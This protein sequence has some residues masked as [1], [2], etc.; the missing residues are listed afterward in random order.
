MSEKHNLNI[1]TYSLE[2]LLSLFDLSYDITVEGLKKAKKKV[3]MLHPDKSNLSTEYFIFYKKAYEI[4]FNFYEERNRQMRNVPTEPMKYIPSNKDN[5]TAKHIHTVISEMSKEKFQESFND[6]FEKNMIKKTDTSRNEWFQKAEP[7]YDIDKNVSSKNL[8][9]AF[10]SIKEKNMGMVK[11]RGVETLQSNSGA[12]AS[13][14]DDDNETGDEYVSCDP[15]SK[16]KF[17]DLR[18][19]HKDQTI[20]TVSEKDYQKVKTYNSMDHLIQERGK[21]TLTPL[22]KTQAEL[23]LEEQQKN[24][25]KAIMQKQ[26]QSK[27]RTMDYEEKNKTIISNFLRLQ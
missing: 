27:L 23:L 20:L 16:L 13:F 4:V 6:M 17:E 15:F 19:V 1:N 3:L 9:E 25:Q 26:Y 14:Y 22:E 5:R 7:I 21:Q 10:E 2:E 8:G 18:K 12:A 24:Y 11:Y